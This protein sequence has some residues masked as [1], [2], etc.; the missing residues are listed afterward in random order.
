MRLEP[1]GA[2]SRKEGREC[3]SWLWPLFL[4]K[5]L[6]TGTAG[7]V[8]SG[9]WP[10]VSAGASALALAQLWSTGIAGSVLSGSWPL[11]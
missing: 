7:S 9:S 10:F 5:P 1:R 4:A 11:A 8:L 6:L 2:V 3:S